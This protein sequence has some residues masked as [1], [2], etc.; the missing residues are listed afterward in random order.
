MTNTKTKIDTLN[1]NNLIDQHKTKSSLIR[2]LNKEG[3]TRSEISKFMNIRY[4]H[5]RNVLT[6]PLKKNK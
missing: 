5:V 3:Y 6:E 4:Q 1:Y 2:Y